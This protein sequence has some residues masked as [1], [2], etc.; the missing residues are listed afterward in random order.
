MAVGACEFAA[1][2]AR[3]EK[4]PVGG[5][6]DACMDGVS[7]C[8]EKNFKNKNMQ[9]YGLVSIITPT[10]ACASFI[11][12]TIRSVM[13]QSYQNWELLIQ[14]GCPTDNAKVVVVHREK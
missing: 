8:V 10:W 3:A 5:S 9:D 13:A 7:F 12:E 1:R 4:I 6:L 11:S 2:N 14:D